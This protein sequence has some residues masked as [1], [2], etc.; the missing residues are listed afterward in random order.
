[1]ENAIVAVVSS[2]PVFIFS[3]YFQSPGRT[4]HRRLIVRALDNQERISWVLTQTHRVAGTFLQW[5]LDARSFVPESGVILD[6]H[7]GG[8]QGGPCQ[9][10]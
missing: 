9:I 8:L 7:R 5:L 6:H 4:G 1:M 10:L 2:P 3:L